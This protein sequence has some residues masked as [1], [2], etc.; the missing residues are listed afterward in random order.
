MLLASQAIAAG[1]PAVLWSVPEG[2]RAIVTL[3]ICN[4]GAGRPKVGVALK[5]GGAAVGNADWIEFDT[6]IAPAGSIDGSVLE[7]TGLM[8]TAGD[9]IWVSASLAN[10]SA[11]LWGLVED[12]V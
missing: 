2:K 8:L 3:N 6:P 4:R 9:R 10:V 11:V 1:A 12:L 7:R 5:A